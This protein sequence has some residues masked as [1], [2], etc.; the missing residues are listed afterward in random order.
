MRLPCRQSGPFPFPLQ[1]YSIVKEHEIYFLS[2]CGL[3]RNGAK[4]PPS[5]STKYASEPSMER[6]NCGVP[7][8]KA[9][10][11]VFMSSR[12]NLSAYPIAWNGLPTHQNIRQRKASFIPVSI[13]PAPAWPKWRGEVEIEP[14][15][16]PT[17]PT[18]QKYTAINVAV[19]KYDAY[20]GYA[21]KITCSECGFCSGEW[22]DYDEMVAWWNKYAR[23][24][25]SK[26]PPRE[27]HVHNL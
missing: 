5:L 12:T 17:C 11:I 23:A 9:K 27:N 20:F 7:M 13:P 4:T 8:P 2:F 26:R 14:C 25:F 3:P 10:P 22:R 6:H 24:E 21:Y 16:N 1:H 18:H 19:D 15:P